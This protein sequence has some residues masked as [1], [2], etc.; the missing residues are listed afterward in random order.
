MQAPEMRSWQERAEYLADQLR[1]DTEE[2]QGILSSSR[3]QIEDLKRHLETRGNRGDLEQEVKRL[4]KE[5][6]KVNRVSVM[7]ETTIPSFSSPLALPFYTDLQQG[8]P[9]ILFKRW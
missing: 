7:P 4:E 8:P 2:M 1:R 3:A 9:N 6:E 5:L